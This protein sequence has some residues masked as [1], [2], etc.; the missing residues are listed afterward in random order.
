MVIDSEKK[1]IN[2]KLFKE[3]KKRIIDT[4]INIYRET[5]K[6]QAWIIIFIL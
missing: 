2:E 3:K 6:N 5:K 4:E 1:E